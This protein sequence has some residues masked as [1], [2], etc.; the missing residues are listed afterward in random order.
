VGAPERPRDF[1]NGTNPSI[2]VGP[3][4]GPARVLWDRS[5]ARARVVFCCHF[6]ASANRRSGI[7]WRPAPPF[8]VDLRGGLSFL[9]ERGG[10]ERRV[11]EVVVPS[12]LAVPE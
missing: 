1:P 5:D 6:C 4:A 8:V 7:Q 3:A 12:D 9:A 11:V 10:P 2:W